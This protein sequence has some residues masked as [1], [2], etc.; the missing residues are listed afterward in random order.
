[1]RLRILAAATGI[2]ALALAGCA[3]GTSGPPDW[4]PKPSFSGE[5]GAAP[6]LPQ[7]GIPSTQPPQQS[8]PSSPSSRR[9]SKAPKTDPTVVA[10]NLTTPTAIAIMPDGTALVGE[11]TTGRIVRV[12]PVAGRPV[13][14]V[15]TLSGLRTTGDGGLLDLALSPNYEQDN[16]VFAYVT[17]RR[18]NR[19]VAF[20]LHGPVT[21][22]VTGIPVGRT[23][24]AGRIVFG[25]AGN[26]YVGTGDAGRPRLAGD[27]SSLAGKILRVTDIG[28][29]AP[30]NPIRSR[31]WASGFGSVAGLCINPDSGAVFETEQR[32][33]PDPVNLVG[34]GASYG[35]PDTAGQYDPPVAVLPSGKDAP[36]GCAVLGPNLYV[37]SL[38]GR[39]LL[40]TSA[41][42]NTGALGDFATLLPGRYGRLRTVVADD[43]GALWLT[44]SN[45]DG[46]GSP[47]RLDERV[48][49][50][51]P[52][53]GSS[54][55]AA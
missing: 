27:P 13:H 35:V 55:D 43:A 45:R 12:Q 2:A 4:R 40:M 48:L 17:T 10:T 20:T 5:G 25:P 42:P 29:P 32:A 51:I 47:V 39:A 34:A 24:N 11:R 30:G 46:H 9:P 31:V 23:G 18:D 8:R 1:M 19:V 7:P 50:I 33:G 22:V 28:R 53:G 52:S 16:L 54:S 21:P 26:L 14:T 37:T 36:G 15:R 3:P 38:T 6:G 44:T 49:H 41:Q